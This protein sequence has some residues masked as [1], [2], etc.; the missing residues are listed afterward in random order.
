MK[1]LNNFI[2]EKLKIN[3][4]SKIN[5]YNYKPK[6]KDELKEI[7]NNL[8]KE[9][10]Y[11]ADLNDINTSEIK[12]M[13]DLF[14][15]IKFNGD[16][17]NWDVSNVKDMSYMFYNTPFNGNISNWDVSNVENMKTMFWMS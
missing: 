4:K 9:R 1:Q 6:D 17:S 2:N 8:I 16:I 12:D 10:G 3:S 7:V 11:N 5:H 15:D 13:S 14:Y